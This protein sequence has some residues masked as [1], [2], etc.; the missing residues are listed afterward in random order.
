MI[1]GPDCNM[2]ADFGVKNRL[3]FYKKSAPMRV[4]L[5]THETL[6]AESFLSFYKKVRAIRVHPLWK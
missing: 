5:L 3:N 4:H 2:R 6:P 1:V